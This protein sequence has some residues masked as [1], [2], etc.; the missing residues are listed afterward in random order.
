MIW[1][2]K[3]SF[4]VKRRC[5]QF[6]M[7][8]LHR[9]PQKSDLSLAL[10]SIVPSSCQIFPKLPNRSECWREKTN[11]LCGGRCAAEIL[12]ETERSAN[13]RGNTC[14]LQERMQDTHCC[15]CWSHRHRGCP[16]SATRWP[17]ESN[18]LCIKKSYWCGKEIFPD[19]KRRP[20]HSMGLWEIQ[21]V[22][23]WS[24]IWAGDWP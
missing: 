13:P 6:K 19:G 9:A 7:P 17:V 20:C 18:F 5:L 14:L 12:P 23:F 22:R 1:A 10:Y 8:S 24:R 16:H 3:E 15:W 21:A 2:V 4:Q 11:S